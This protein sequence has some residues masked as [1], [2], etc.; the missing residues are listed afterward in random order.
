MNN[1]KDIIMHTTQSLEDVL[2]R[3]IANP[4]NPMVIKDM[5]IGKFILHSYYSTPDK[6]LYPESFNSLARNFEDSFRTSIHH[7]GFSPPSI[8]YVMSTDSNFKNI[9]ASLCLTKISSGCPIPEN[10]ICPESWYLFNVCTYSPYRRKGFMSYLLTSAF[11]D[12]KVYISSPP[13]KIY[14]LVDYNNKPAKNLYIK[15]G[16]QVIGTTFQQG[17]I[18]EIM[19]LDIS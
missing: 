5:Y 14:L 18:S 15:L 7:I 3:L 16:F 19:K 13:F 10:Y 4:R 17:S 9:I 1:E 2:N 11:T 12:L 6:I 8:T